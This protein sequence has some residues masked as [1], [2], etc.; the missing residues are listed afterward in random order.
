M[1]ILACF[2][3]PHGS[4][5]LD[6]SI[7]ADVSTL[8]AAM[9][10]FGEKVQKLQPD[11]VFLTTPHSIALDYEFGIY[12]NSKARGT[13]GWEGQ[14][15]EFS[16]EID[17]DTEFSDQLINQLT[18]Q[19]AA[20]KGITCFSP[21]V[22]E[23]PLRWGEVVPLWF[24]REVQT[25]YI[26]MSQPLRRYQPLDMTKE[27]LMMGQ[28]LYDFLQTSAKR[29]VVVVSGDLAHTH[30]DGLHYRYSSSAEPFDQAIEDWVRSQNIE[31]L[32]VT[33]G[34]FLEEAL[35]CGY[36]SFVMLHGL[37][38]RGNFRNEFVVRSHPTYFGMLVASFQVN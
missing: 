2:I 23:A 35:C 36:A 9:E 16:A 28:S 26:V 4:M 5:V 19:E 8:H 34:S 31:D 20:V 33:A 6:P 17:L 15:D 37:L 14:Y 18:K 30:Q 7:G 13:A 21:S 29:V 12:R 38:E 11:I 22:G 24:L 1:T 25:K 32:V 3:V 27:L 10:Q